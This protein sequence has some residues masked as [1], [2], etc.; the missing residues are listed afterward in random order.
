VFHLSRNR[1]LR[2]V[3]SAF[4]MVLIISGALYSGYLFFS[5]VR[6]LTARTALPFSPVSV[7]ADTTSG[8]APEE[9]LPDVA[10]EKERVNILLLGIDQRENDPGPWRTDTMI[11]LSIDPATD[12][13]A[14]L[15]IPRDL[16]T[17]IPGFGESRI[18]TAHLLGDA[19]DYPG[20]GV[21][22][23]KK[24]VWHTF[25][26]PVHYYVRINFTGFEKLV[27]AVGGL[28]IDVEEPIHDEEYP[29]GSY[30]TMVVDIPAGL[31]QMDGQTAL[32]YARSRHG[33]DDFDRMA[34]Q[35]AVIMA[36]RDKALSLDIPISR[37]PKLLELA[38]DTVKTDLTLE[39][40]IALAK[41]AK[42]ID[43]SAIE[44]SVIDDSMTTTVITPE[45]WMVEVADW[46]KVQTLVEELFPSPVP[47]AAPT[48][49]LSE[50]RLQ[51]EKA[52]IVLQNGTLV[53][54]LAQ[55]TELLL[56][57]EGFDVVHYENADRF[58]YKST[59]FVSYSDKPYTLDALA[60]ALGVDADEVF[61][62][63]SSP[64]DIDIRVILGRDY[65]QG[66]EQ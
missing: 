5:T 62:E 38:G 48:P 56:R 21:A 54:G 15:S 47:S 32:Q 37:I 22:L 43:R 55:K 30:G 52:R 60:T 4:F 53:P 25:G 49:S 45:N 16:W 7:Q 42:R 24:T 11:L 36:A 28:T 41:I 20:G 9:A 31:Q 33:S 58:D 10:E 14:M 46:E 65:A 2:R 61:E 40:M 29:D 12:S 63:E 44:H 6:A 26:V 18:N 50:S 3:L 19:H 35:Q 17:T 57:E 51:A 64:A 13:A 1:N 27:D 23:A 34:R 39:E 59:T 66:Q 8:R